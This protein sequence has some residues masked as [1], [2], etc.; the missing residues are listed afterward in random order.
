SGVADDE[1]LV[2]EA[3][4]VRRHARAR[5]VVGRHDELEPGPRAPASH[6]RA[7][8]AEDALEALTGGRGRDHALPG[9]L[10]LGP[11]RL[12]LLGVEVDLGHERRR[13]RADAARPRDLGGLGAV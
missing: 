11:V 3:P 6:L 13:A 1:E 12:R 10:R 5:A 8:V 9:A 2:D 7:R 4:G